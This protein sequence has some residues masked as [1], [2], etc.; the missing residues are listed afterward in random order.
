MTG[1]EK[2]R[3]FPQLGMMQIADKYLTVYYKRVFSPGGKDKDGNRFPA[4]SPGY[5]KLLSRDFKRIKD[6]KRLKGYGQ[7]SL[8][9]GGSKLSTRPLYLRGLTA[10]N[11]RRR[12]C[13]SEYFEIGWDGEAATIMKAQAESGRDAIND[14]PN[15]EKDWVINEI[16]KLF[17]KEVAQKVKDRTVINISV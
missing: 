9:T 15:K 3:I 7:Y 2:I 11:T 17:D 1:L 16:G 10:K 14:I 13:T 8:T 5:K 4:Y 6:S 12:T